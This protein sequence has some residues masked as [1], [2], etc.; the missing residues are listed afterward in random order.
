MNKWFLPWCVVFIVWVAVGSSGKDGMGRDLMDR[1]EHGYADNNGVRIHY[2]TLGDGPLILLLHGFPDFWYSWRYQMQ[3]LAKEHRVA[4]LDLRGYNRSDKPEGGENYAMDRLVTDVAA[5]IRDCGAEKAFVVGHDWGGVIAWAFAQ[6]FPEMTE[7]LIALNFP[8][9]R[10][11]ANALATNETQRKNSAYARAFLQEGAH[12]NLT[13]EEMASWVAGP[14]LVDRAR[15][16]EAFERSDFEAMLH[17]YKQ[18]FPREPYAPPDDDAVKV[19]T[20]V[21]VIH[22][23]DDPYVTHYG[24]NNN[25]E[26]I[27]K[28]LTIVTIPGAGHFVQHDAPDLVTRTILMWLTRDR[29]PLETTETTRR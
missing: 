1:V 26:W 18:N 23:L 8:H 7:R 22:G 27:E 19:K 17:Y 15:Y 5:V 28:D 16:V 25:W 13:A 9:P 3:P 14:N 24:L 2:V 12:Q 29:R 4:A 20:P 10:G 11:F 6:T 21:L